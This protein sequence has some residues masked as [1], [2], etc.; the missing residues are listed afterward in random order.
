MYP[1]EL[2]KGDSLYAPLS[3]KVLCHFQQATCHQ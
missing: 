3:G 1:V 2:S